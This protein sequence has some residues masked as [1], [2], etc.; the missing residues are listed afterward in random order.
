MKTSSN[1]LAFIAQWEGF[2][3]TAYMDD[4]DG[5]TI[6]YGTL[7]DEDKEAYLINATISESEALELKKKD[8][9]FV[10]S[11]IRG[12]VGAPLNQNQFD[13]LVSLIYNIGSG[14]FQDSTVRAR[15]NN[16]D[17]PENIA[18][19]WKRWKKDDGVVVQGLINRRAKEVELFQTQ[20]KKKTLITALVIAVIILILVLKFRK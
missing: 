6:G 7:I 15:I 8:V 18:E 2:S 14:Q 19:A 20:P 5:W 17:T 3:A 10:E 1:G 12:Q 16:Y 9:A 13:A 4:E 11:V